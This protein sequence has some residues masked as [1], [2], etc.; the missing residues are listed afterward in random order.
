MRV[1]IRAAVIG[2][3]PWITDEIR[4]MAAE[5]TYFSSLYSEKHSPKVV[6]QLIT[7]GVSIVAENADKKKLGFI[8]KPL[9]ILF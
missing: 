8:K 4:E 2:D 5:Q 9:K 6:E 1:Y 3:K 7:R